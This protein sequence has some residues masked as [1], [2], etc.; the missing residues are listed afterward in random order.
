MCVCVYIDGENNALMVRSTIGI[1]TSFDVV[2]LLYVCRDRAHGI[3]FWH[4]TDIYF[5]RFKYL[6]MW[7]G[8]DLY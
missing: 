6:V 1:E 3:V 2:V 5:I 4:S 7:A 8:A